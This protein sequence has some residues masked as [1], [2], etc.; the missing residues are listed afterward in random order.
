MQLK[1]CEQG[2]VDRTQPVLRHDDYVALQT[3]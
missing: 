2:V 1:Y 3:Y